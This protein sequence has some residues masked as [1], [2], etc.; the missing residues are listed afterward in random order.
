MPFAGRDKLIFLIFLAEGRWHVNITQILQGNVLIFQKY[1]SSV[2]WGQASCSCSASRCVAAQR[3][4][5]QRKR[6]SKILLCLHY[7]AQM[8]CKAWQDC[9]GPRLHIVPN[10]SVTF[11]HPCRAAPLYHSNNRVRCQLGNAADTHNNK[12]KSM[13][14]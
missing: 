11:C 14:L 3:G 1:M 6:E 10:S 13:G 7:R 4:L 5:H 12:A 9:S 2:G 8:W